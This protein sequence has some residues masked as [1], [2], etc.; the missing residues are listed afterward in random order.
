MLCYPRQ[1]TYP[2]LSDRPR[3]SERQVTPTVEWGSDAIV[4]QLSRL[5]LTYIALVPA[6][7]YRGLHDSLINYHNNLQP[8]VVVC[9]H[10]EHAVAIAHGYAKISER[11]MA[12]AVHSNVGLMHA[13]TAI[14]DAFCDRVPMIILGSTGLVE[15][16][17]RSLRVDQIHTA[18]DQTALIR[19]FV[20]FDD[21]PSS[22][23]A[24][25]AS[26][27]RAKSVTT[28]K[29]SA[30][31][32]ISLD[33]SLLEEKVDATS[34]L[35]PETSRYMQAALTPAGPTSQEVTN[36][37]TAFGHAK[38]PLLL[39]GRLNSSLTGW[40]ERIKLSE[41]YDARVLTDSKQASP[42]PTSHKLHA[43]PPGISSSARMSKFIRSADLI[44][45]FDWVDLAGTLQAAHPAGV[46]P[47]SKIVHIS[48]D[49]ALHNGWSKDNFGFP[50][51]DIAVHAD[52]DQVVSALVANLPNMIKRSS[53][54][55]IPSMNQLNINAEADPVVEKHSESISI[56]NLASSLAKAIESVSPSSMC[57][58][59]VPPSWKG[60][61]IRATH[62][63][64]Y[65][66]QHGGAG[67]GLG[68][69]HAVGMALALKELRAPHVRLPRREIGGV[70]QCLQW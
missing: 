54:W 3:R 39:F 31:V 59:R 21:Q 36:I 24:A 61:D 19:P 16:G 53:D 20:K 47:A 13:T 8:E 15:A 9:L 37:I 6:S 41:F 11:S 42:F 14:S 23:N 68:P 30:P 2:P 26:L 50:P 18:I 46:E 29:P 43:C 70:G 4:E 12:V 32:Y 33:S 10:E 69:G 28:T 35:Y 38:R 64:A 60:S 55:S 7:G 62:S 65:F 22:V 51:I 5:D 1:L 40:L 58:I 27:I 25:I 17:E 34:I 44:V 67:V 56:S 45:S 48:L 52:P 49:A 57:L 66:G 63:Y